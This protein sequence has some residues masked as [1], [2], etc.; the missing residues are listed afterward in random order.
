[1]DGRLAPHHS[2]EVVQC[3]HAGD[4]YQVVWE[5]VGMLPG[6][7]GPGLTV[8][9]SSLPGRVALAGVLKPPTTPLRLQLGGGYGHT[10]SWAQ[11]GEGRVL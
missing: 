9:G 1:M 2:G 11:G 7:R 8:L 6:Q 10:G 4:P 3:H 5:R